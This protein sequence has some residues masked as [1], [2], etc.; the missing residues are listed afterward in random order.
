MNIVLIGGPGSGKGTLAKQLKN[1]VDFYTISPGELYRKEANEGTEFGIKAR[2]EYWGAGNLCPDE[3]TNELVKNTINKLGDKSFIFDGY[4]R[5]K[6]QAEYLDSIIDI[7]FILDLI[8]SKDVVVKRL[9]KRATIENRPDDT[10]EIIEQRFDVYQTNMNG[11]VSYYWGDE[12]YHTVD[13][14]GT[15]DDTLRLALN[16][17]KI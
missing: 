3:M 1:R 15:M 5:T 6:I 4:P 14:D 16:I 10:R 13:A 2:D 11:L 7:D 12:R 17:L 8:S 9:L